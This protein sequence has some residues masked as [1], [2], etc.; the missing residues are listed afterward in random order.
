M[1]LPAAA[2]C[3]WLSGAPSPSSPQLQQLPHTW[4]QP[5]GG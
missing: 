1:A 5:L 2:F 4:D 3:Q